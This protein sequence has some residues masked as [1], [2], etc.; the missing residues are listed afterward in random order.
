VTPSNC[1]VVP[2]AGDVIETIR[3]AL[4]KIQKGRIEKLNA[5]LDALKSTFSSWVGGMNYITVL[6]DILKSGKDVDAYIEEHGYKTTEEAKI[7]ALRD[8]AEAYRKEIGPPFRPGAKF[9]DKYDT[10][11]AVGMLAAN[12]PIEL[13]KKMKAILYYESSGQSNWPSADIISKPAKM[14]GMG[15]LSP[16]YHQEL[17]L[18]PEQYTAEQMRVIKEYNAEVACR[19]MAQHLAAAGGDF[20]EGAR[21]YVAGPAGART[22]TNGKANQ[23]AESKAAIIQSSKDYANGVR[24]NSYYHLYGS[25]PWEKY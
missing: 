23:T 22:G 3:S 17:A 18:N 24:A 19:F 25:Y 15:Q 5:E 2:V 9:P 13:A 7:V 12:W 16:K 14:C 8:K 1:Q 11:I 6:T 4:V 10:E 21:Y 20:R